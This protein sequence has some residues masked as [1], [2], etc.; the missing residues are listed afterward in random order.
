MTVAR[1]RFAAR[2]A[3]RDAARLVSGRRGGRLPRSAPARR[4]R[5]SASRAAGR[6]P[7]ARDR[8]ASCRAAGA[9][10]GRGP[11]PRPRL[12]LARGRAPRA[13]RAR[14]RDVVPGAAS[15]LEPV[16]TVGE[17]VAET[18]A[19]TAAV[20][21]FR[22]GPRVRVCSEVGLEE[23][24]RARAVPAR[25]L[26]RAAAARDARDGAR[27]RSVA[28]DRGRADERARHARAGG[29][30]RLFAG[31]A[32]GARWRCCSSRTTSRSSRSAPTS[33]SP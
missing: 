15:A 30:P 1:S 22:L 4:W 11:L 25:A 21:R 28:P 13:G 6:P 16:L 32:R 10:R 29:D 9:S 19:H 8:S 33:A 20:A 14:A 24:A 27:V 17:Q 26:R 23:A 2:V 31:C 3:L 5:W 12:R 18:L 7:R